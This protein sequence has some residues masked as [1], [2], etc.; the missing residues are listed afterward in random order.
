MFPYKPY[1][2][3]IELFADNTVYAYLRMVTSALLSLPPWE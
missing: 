2:D 1:V 3:Y